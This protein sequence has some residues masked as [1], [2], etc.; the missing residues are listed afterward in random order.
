MGIQDRDYYHEKRYDKNHR[1]GRKPTTSNLA[2]LSWKTFV[3][4]VLIWI[5]LALIF[6]AVLHYHKPLQQNHF[7]AAKNAPAAIAMLRNC[8]SLPPHGSSYAIDPSVMKRTDVLYSGLE[9]QNKHDYPMVAILS[10][11][12]GSRRFF[13][14]SIS[15][16]NA[17]QVSVPAGQYGMQVLVGSDWCNLETGFSDGA[18]VSVSGGIT[19]KAGSTTFMQFNGSGLRPIQLAL[20]YSISQ[21]VDSQNIKQSS[22]VI[23]IG[24]LELRQTHDGHYFSSGTVNGSPVV[25]MIDTGATT[26]SISSEIAERAGIEKCS[27]HLVLTANGKVNACKT[28]VPEVTF[29]KFRLTHVEVTIMPNMPGNALLGMNVLRNFHIEQIDEIMRISSR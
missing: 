11:S 26:V 20:A 5:V 18:A 2:N 25:F 6:L 7:Q 1:G 23:G 16:G 8:E 10:D 9:I 17:A 12:S 3:R 14:V 19:V 13:A 4:A 27:P 15:S 28:T 22:E 24:K 29:G 21:P